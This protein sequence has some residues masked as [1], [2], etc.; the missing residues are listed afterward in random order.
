MFYEASITPIPKM[1]KRTKQRQNHKSIYL[2]N[3]DLKKKKLKI[4]AML[5]IKFIHLELFLIFPYYS[6]NVSEN[7]VIFPLSF[8]MLV[9]CV[10]FFPLSVLL[11]A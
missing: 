5:V 1:V 6:F 2:K 11:E 7:D 8:L 3:I 10:I 9:N 4:L